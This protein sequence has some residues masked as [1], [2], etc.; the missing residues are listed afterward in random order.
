MCDGN[1]CT[2]FMV[3]IPWEGYRWYWWLLPWRMRLAW[4]RRRCARRIRNIGKYPIVI[5]KEMLKHFDMDIREVL[6]VQPMSKEAGPQVKGLF[7]YN[8]VP[9]RRMM[10]N[11]GKRGS[12]DAS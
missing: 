8:I 1:V 4:R 9:H 10:A 2:G 11:K 7:Y 12:N 3:D 5:P 6:S